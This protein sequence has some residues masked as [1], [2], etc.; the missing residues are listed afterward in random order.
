MEQVGEKIKRIRK[1][2]K[3]T[4][5]MISEETKLSISFLSQMER[6]LTSITLVSLKKIT[7]ALGITMGDLFQ[8][9]EE[10]QSFIHGSNDERLQGI[11]RDFIDYSLLNG[12]FPGR[13]LECLSLKMA[14]YYTE[15]EETTHPGEEFFY[16]LKG[17]GIFVVDGK[18]Y[19][20][21][22]GQSIH[23]PSK[24]PHKVRNE[25]SQELEMLCIVTPTIF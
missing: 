13:N 18:E 8:E 21:K 25:R 23:Y 3:I 16:V 1:E 11:R 4:L 12:K 17:A 9:T 22:E 20:V 15:C 2:R 6:G 7:D 24:Y 14:P 5:S 10:N 19:E